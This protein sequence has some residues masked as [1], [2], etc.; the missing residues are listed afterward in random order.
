MFFNVQKGREKLNLPN[1]LFF[2]VPLHTFRLA[3]G[4]SPGCTSTSV[5]GQSL[6]VHKGIVIFCCLCLFSIDSQN[7][8]DFSHRLTFRNNFGKKGQTQRQISTYPFLSVHWKTKQ[9]NTFKQNYHIHIEEVEYP[10]CAYICI[11]YVCSHIVTDLHFGANMRF[12][13]VEGISK[14]W[15]LFRFLKNNNTYPLVI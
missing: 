1:S 3:M 4:N 5:H 11:I 8:Q 14:W 9:V 13:S 6:I 12:L 7:L 2:L 15:V 10:V